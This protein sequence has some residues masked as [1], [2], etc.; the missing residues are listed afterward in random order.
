MRHAL[1]YGALLRSPRRWSRAKKFAA[2]SSALR[3][4]GLA[5]VANAALSRVSGGE[6]RRAGAAL[7]LLAE[8]PVLLMDEPTSGLDAH[9]ALALL[10]TFA[11]VAQ[12][13]RRNVVAVVHQPSFA[14][15]S[16]CR[17]VVVLCDSIS[18]SAPMSLHHAWSH[19]S[20]TRRRHQGK[21]Q[22]KVKI[23]QPSGKMYQQ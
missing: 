21:E 14:A 18:T 23:L 1:F 7:E 11:D 8:R 12:A 2:A 17:R 4:L 5:K 10:K 9:A 19:Q 20:S 6:R 3:S 22:G 13:Q 16:T 15:L